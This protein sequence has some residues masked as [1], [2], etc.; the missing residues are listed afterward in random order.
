MLEARELHRSFGRIHAVRGVSFRVEK[1]EVLG[2]LGPNGAGKSTTMRMLTG[3]L[4]PSSGIA[5]VCGFDVAK[6]PLGAK[7]SVGYLPE[8]APVYGDMTVRSFLRFIAE[9]R[10]FRGR[11]AAAAIDRVIGLCHLERVVSQPV[12]T[13]SKGYKHRTCL[14]QAVLHDPP[15]LLM[16][17]PT[18][19][20]DPNQ[21]HIVREM[22]RGMAPEKV[23]V[24]STHILEEVDAICTRAII[25][26][27]GVIVA[28]STPAELK[29]RSRWHGAVELTFEDGKDWRPEL[30]AIG[31]ASSVEKSGSRYTLFPARREQL[32]GDV[33]AFLRDKRVHP[34]GMRVTEGKLDEVFRELTAGAETIRKSK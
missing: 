14:A 4:P 2:F 7:R 34:A 30:A 18:D 19:G 32:L 22:I 28:N 12:D 10:G 5:S 27:N 6:N 24:I 16:D 33:N 21:K 25:I 15:V 23:I 13:L 17:E 3:F 8:N 11:A 26:A 20:L 9:M 29:G 1:G 31:S